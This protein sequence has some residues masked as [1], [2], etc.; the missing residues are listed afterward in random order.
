[1]GDFASVISIPKQMDPRCINFVVKL[2][3]ISSEA[4]HFAA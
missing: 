2:A 4:P 3:N 1:M